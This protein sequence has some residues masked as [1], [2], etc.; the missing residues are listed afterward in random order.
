MAEKKESYEKIIAELTAHGYQTHAGKPFS[1]ATLSD[2]LRN[3][4]Y[5]GVYV[6]CRKD[7]DGNPINR[8]RHRV[9]LGEQEEVR[10][11]DTVLQAIIP[12]AQF[13]K[14]QKMLDDRELGSTKQNTRPEYLLSGLVR[15]VCGKGMHGET[16]K[17]T[18]GKGVYRYYV[19][20]SQRNKQGCTTTKIDADYLEAAVKKVVYREVQV[21]LKQ[22]VQS[23]EMVEAKQKEYQGKIGHL[24]RRIQDIERENGKLVH[25]LSQVEESLATVL[26]KKIK[27]NVEVIETMQKKSEKLKTI[28]QYMELLKSPE[29]KTIEEKRLFADVELTRRL[30]RLFVKGVIISKEGVEIQMNS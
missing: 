8:K 13:L 24:S 27:D 22:N 29:G 12:K 5:A 26:E 15:C 10:N 28:V 6:Y 2:M 14:V 1:K 19:C 18:R 25:R 23:I 7:K 4:K 30:I 21:L 9:L 17:G 16:V 20:P 11:D 3:W